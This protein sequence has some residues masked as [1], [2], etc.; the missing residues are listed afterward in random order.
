[1]RAGDSPEYDSF[2]NQEQDRKVA[3][4]SNT[5]SAERLYKTSKQVSDSQSNSL[6]SWASTSDNYEAVAEITAE[7]AES[8]NTTKSCN[9]QNTFHLKGTTHKEH[10]QDCI[11]Q[12]TELDGTAV[13]EISTREHFEPLD[14]SHVTDFWDQVQ[15][16][17]GTAIE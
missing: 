6:A 8:T 3:K 7:I 1:M 17:I 4:H 13:Q 12:N 5:K 14:I 10:D 2:V 9:E 16:E 15:L 11:L